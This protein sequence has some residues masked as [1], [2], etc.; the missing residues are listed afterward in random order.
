MAQEEA[1]AAPDSAVAPAAATVKLVGTVTYKPVR[2]GVKS[3]AAYTG[4]ELFL[5]TDD[6]R[7]VVLQPSEAHSKES[8]GALD[9]ARVEIEAEETEGTLP[10]PH[11]SYPMG[12][13]GQPIRRDAGFIVRSVR[14]L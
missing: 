5:A 11:E 12:P 14:P 9:G 7:K 6:G 2:R 10:D 8:L 1:A 3:V 13:D 4:D